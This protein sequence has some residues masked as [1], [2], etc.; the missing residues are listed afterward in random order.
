MGCLSDKSNL[1]NLNDSPIPEGVMSISKSI[2]KMNCHDK[3]SRGFLIKFFRDDK[4]FFCLM[5]G[6]EKIISQEM[7]NN[8]EDIKFF[9]N[10]EANMKKI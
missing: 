2:A 7:I 4:E 9:Y 1:G 3:M 6:G 10:D 5:T 8:K